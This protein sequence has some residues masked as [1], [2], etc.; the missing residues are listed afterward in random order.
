MSLTELK[1]RSWHGS[2]GRESIPLPSPASRDYLH[3]LAHG[4]FLHLQTQYYSIF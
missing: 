1:P 2:S 4:S 3:F